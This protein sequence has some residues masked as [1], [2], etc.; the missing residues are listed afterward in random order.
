MAFTHASALGTCGSL[1]NVIQGPVAEHLAI[2]EDDFEQV[3]VHLA[4]AGTVH[5]LQSAR[6]S[7]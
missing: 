3:A 2:A 5:G 4:V 1:A 6:G 7:D